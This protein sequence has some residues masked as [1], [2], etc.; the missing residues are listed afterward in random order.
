MLAKVSG[1]SI[2]FQRLREEWKNQVKRKE[3]RTWRK[4]TTANLLR[5]QRRSEDRR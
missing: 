4:P 3:V 5:P 1:A 2:L